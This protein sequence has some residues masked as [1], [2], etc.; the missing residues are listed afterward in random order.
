L[1][2]LDRGRQLLLSKLVHAQNTRRHTA[3]PTVLSVAAI[4]GSDL[5]HTESPLG[6]LYPLSFS[7]SLVYALER[8]RV[9]KPKVT[10]QWSDGAETTGVFTEQRVEGEG[11]GDSGRWLRFCVFKL[12][13]GVTRSLFTSGI[14]KVTLAS[15]VKIFPADLYVERGTYV[16]QDTGVVKEYSR[17]RARGEQVPRYKISCEVTDE[18]ESSEAVRV[19]CVLRELGLSVPRVAA[20]TRKLQVKD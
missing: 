3:C 7:N 13:A 4:G 15:G 9:L 20:W 6:V 18:D 1:T 17:L 19:N 11:E 12:S 16:Q 10:V 8:L 2:R 14:V 5:Y